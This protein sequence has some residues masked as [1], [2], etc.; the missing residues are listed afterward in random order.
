M[1]KSSKTKTKQP[2]AAEFWIGLGAS[3]GGLEALRGF[4]RNVPND[5]SATYIIAQHMSPHHK[6]ML[7]DIIGRE[8][9]MEV[10]EITDSLVPLPNTV[11]ITPPNSNVI[12]EKDQLRLADPSKSIAAPK[13]SVDVFLASLA[14]A[15]GEKAVAVILS[16]T[17]SDGAKGIQAVHEK[18]GVTVAQDEMTAKYS[19]MPSAAIETG[20]VDLVMS[21]EELGAQLSQVIT[22]PRNL[23]ILKA[24]PINLD[25]VSELLS[26]L[27]NQ[28]KVNFKCY[29]TP[30]FQRRVARRMAAVKVTTLPEYVK[31]AREQ[32][33][34]VKELFKDLLISVTAFFRD[35][36]EF[37]ALRYHLR[38]LVQNTEDNF[39][40]VWIPGVATGEEAYSIAI[41]FHEICREYDPPKQCRLQ[42]F[43]TDIDANAIETAR[44]GFYPQ[45]EFTEMDSD[46]IKRYFDPAPKGYQVK[47][48]IREKVVFSIHNVAQD[49][50]FLNLDLV[51]C[52]NL[53]IYFQAQLQAEVFARFHYSLKP[54]GLLFL[55][56][57]EA[58]AASED[59]FRLSDRDKHI[60]FQRP[61]VVRKVPND[62]LQGTPSRL[63]IHP[64]NTYS[65]PKT[66]TQ[67]QQLN[68]RFDALVAA[69]GPNAIITNSD[70]QLVKSF[71]QM[72]KYIGLDAGMVNTKATS[73]LVEPYR[74]DGRFAVPAA[75]RKNT[76]VI[77]NVRQNS[78][79][80]KLKNRIVVYPLAA[81]ENEE[82]LA[83]VVFEEWEETI[84]T[85]DTQGLIPP[86]AIQQFEQL[87][88][89]LAITRTNLQ[90][91]T[92]ELET[93]NE[94]LQAVN[95][96]LQSSNEELQSTNEE[97]ETSNEELQSTNEEL[98]TVN[99]ELQVNAQQLGTLNQDLKGVLHNIS[100]PMIV[101][102]RSM[103]ITYVSA[104][105]ENIFK[106]EA[107]LA[108]PHLSRVQ[109]PDGFPSL[110]DNINKVF[111]DSTSQEFSVDHDNVSA[112]VTISPYYSETHE[113]MGAI[114]VLNDNTQEL[115]DTKNELQLI[116]DNVPEAIKVRD[117]EGRIVRANIA[118]D[119]LLGLTERKSEGTNTYD[120]Y[121]ESIRDEIRKSDLNIL[122]TGI[123]VINEVRKIVYHDGRS[124][125]VRWSRIPVQQPNKDLPL[126]YTV[127][128]DITAEYQSQ[129][130]LIV[131]E[132]RLNAA[133]TATSIGLWERDF[134]SEDIY[135]SDE[136]RKIA[137]FKK[138]EKITFEKFESCVHP[139][140]LELLHKTRIDHIKNGTPYSVEYRFQ[141]HDGK[142][143]WVETSARA[144]LNENG[145]VI[146]F[147]GT[148]TD[149][150]KKKSDFI[151]L[152]TINSQLNLASNLSGVGYW[153]IDL[154]ACTLM[155]SEEV[156]NIHG[157]TPEEYNPELE[158]AI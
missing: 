142:Y 21:P 3:A 106:I 133:I 94:E 114:V 50:P 124:L 78:E 127:K 42:I 141:R 30:T 56:K 58:V 47:K 69:I 87:N 29:K 110:I 63:G 15:K 71:G 17:G 18:G 89:E 115:I 126:L 46:V 152:S 118:T 60:F 121:H 59:L 62:I 109:V 54:N 43:G 88:N 138:D 7:T 83:L 140:D 92:E 155:W 153:V 67:Q 38:K 65:Q 23:D 105:T 6:S 44:R 100:V 79:D 27:H 11:Y 68:E 36:Q 107:D 28:T 95:E 12:V 48:M 53:L 117:A 55:G 66:S 45:A 76:K 125:W 20:K 96:E 149:I 82:I 111:A 34:E 75:L 134:Q 70:F 150:S 104:A 84:P 4:F 144:E 132:R 102:D 31:I 19:S 146:R 148:L 97:L 145:D 137:G 40:R 99:E 22:V 72:T 123:A 13:P 61:N 35:A 116:F 73:L 101:V 32:P 80:P 37:E 154:I 24:S 119:R 25:G 93:S 85:A 86:N 33:D 129:E 130:G 77:G 9:I 26:L 91:T 156:F 51:S 103:N 57:S 112:T 10:L 64:N 52:R 147:T 135:W 120:Y 98:S 74:Q 139:D 113:V 41:L 90:Q 49:P 14:D 151:E 158:S 16:G 108:L 39:I 1:T 136:I 8:T 122:E 131:S 157:L 81:P 143:I 5:L 2:I 128:Q